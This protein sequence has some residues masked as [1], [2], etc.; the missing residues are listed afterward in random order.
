MAEIKAFR[1]LR[2]DP[3]V[4]GDL[5][6][7]V[8]PPYDIISPEEQKAYYEKNKNNVI[9]LEYGMELAGDNELQNK[10]TRAGQQLREFLNTG[11][12]KR[13]DQ[14]CLYVYEQIFQLKNGESKSFKG[15]ICLVKLEEFEKGVVLP[16]EE[17]LS[18]AKSD[19]FRLMCATNCNF[20]QIY[21]LY[22]DEQKKIYPAIDALSSGE[23]DICLT[24][25]DGIQQRVWIVPEGEEVREIIRLFQAEKL[26]IADGHHRYETALNYRNKLR[27]EKGQYD[28]DALFQYVMMFLV[29]MDNEGLLVF[30][31]HRML[32]DLQNFSEEDFLKE[33][34][35]DFAVERCENPK[36][37]ERELSVREGKN[38]GFYT[39]KDYY[40]ILTL[41]NPTLMDERIPEKSEPYR[42][43]DVSILHSGILERFLGIDKENM[44]NQKNLSYTR[45]FSEAIEKV[46]DGTFQCSFILNATKIRE[47]KDVTLYKEKMP[48]KSTYF[49]PKLVTGIVMNQLE[50]VSEQ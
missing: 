43:L 8:T 39:G 6:E 28:E 45:D 20:S 1:G 18:K 24:T 35:A 48:Q 25:D 4:A 36:Q 23:P 10:Y 41:K 27:E 33:V 21:S 9:R 32:R 3:K 12:L 13:E 26:Y 49:W 50:P 42:N 46:Q 29:N 34:S 17:T 40:Y 11:V 47:I 19:R 30:P 22:L 2:Y 16:H 7:L 15:I 31:T 44:A 5:K 14:D 37:M 38:F